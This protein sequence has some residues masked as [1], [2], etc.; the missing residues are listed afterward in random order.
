[1]FESAISSSK[2][3]PKYLHGPSNTSAEMFDWDENEPAFENQEEIEV[4]KIRA[5]TS[6]SSWEGVLK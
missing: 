5:L 1:M 6:N 3:M 2:T 4:E